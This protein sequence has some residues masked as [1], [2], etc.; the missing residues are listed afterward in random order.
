MLKGVVNG[1]TGGRAYFGRPAAGKTGTTSDYHDAWFVG[2]TPDLVAGV[3]I[4]NDSNT[5]L[6]GM[7]GGAKPAEVWK[8]FMSQALKNVPAKDFDG[9]FATKANA[10]SHL[11]ESGD[12]NTK[13]LKDTKKN[14]GKGSK[15]GQAGTNDGKGGG[16]PQGQQPSQ[17]AAPPS[18][19]PSPTGGGEKGRN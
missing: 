9:T 13:G 11:E 1:G 18:A 4:G 16:A 6:G 8:A 19:A 5:S 7:T 14:A 17:P 15:N 12:A 2:Y 10:V 3:W